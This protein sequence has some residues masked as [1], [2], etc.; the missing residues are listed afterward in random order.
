MTASHLEDGSGFAA[1]YLQWQ[2]LP[3]GAGIGPS[4]S[5]KEACGFNELHAE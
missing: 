5:P 4:E 1:N 2:S 3:S